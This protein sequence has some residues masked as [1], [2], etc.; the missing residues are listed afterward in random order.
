[1]TGRRKS[2][3]GPAFEC[4]NVRLSANAEKNLKNYSPFERTARGS[5]LRSLHQAGY[6][7]LVDSVRST[8]GGD[9][10]LEGG[11]IFD[12]CRDQDFQKLDG[13]TRIGGQCRRRGLRD[14]C[15]AGVGQRSHIGCWGG[16]KP[17]RRLGV[18]AGTTVR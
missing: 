6:D 16:V 8:D 10:F 11:G 1:M 13:E 15:R 5:A 2:S 12:E 18:R 4:L 17:H 14:G 3:T 7:G 9:R